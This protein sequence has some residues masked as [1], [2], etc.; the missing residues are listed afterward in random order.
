MKVH[1]LVVSTHYAWHNAFKHSPNQHS[2]S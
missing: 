2:S 1:L